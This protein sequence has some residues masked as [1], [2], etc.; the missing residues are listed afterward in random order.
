MDNSEF[1]RGVSAVHKK[2]GESTAILAGNSLQVMAFEVLVRL[3]NFD[4]IK[5]FCKVAGFNGVM[6][7]Q[8]LDLNPEF[9]KNEFEEMSYKKTG[10][11]IEFCLTSTAILLKREDVIYKLKEYGKNL[12][13]AY[14][15]QDDLLDEGEGGYSY[16][17]HLGGRKFL[18]DK[19]QETIE[20]CKQSIVN[21]ANNDVLF[22]LPKALSKRAY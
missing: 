4:I 6:S 20:I 3:K 12:G 16:L 15:M 14:Q 7:G 19:L 13:I 18:E 8:V 2:F 11:L 22:N 5:E 21:I 9:K 1:R 10:V 17:T